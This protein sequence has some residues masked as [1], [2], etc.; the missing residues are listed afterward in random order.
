MIWGIIAG[1]AFL[2]FCVLLYL[3]VRKNQELSR[4][5]LQERF[6]SLQ[7]L[8]DQKISDTSTITHAE[9]TKL[10][11]RIDGRLRESAE[12][13]E[14]THQT[15]GQ[16]LDKNASLFGEVKHKL[17]QLEESSKRIESVGENISELQEIL[18]APK[19]RGN[20][21]ELFL[22]ELLTQILP[23][24]YFEM[25]YTFHS[26]EKVD[27][28]IRLAHGLVP[29]D[30]KFPLENFQKFLKPHLSEQEE[31]GFRKKFV[32]DLKK[33]VDD[34][35]QR[36]IR[37]DEGTFDFALLYV[38]AENIYYE[39][40]LREDGKKNLLNINAYALERRVIPV[41][42]NSLYAYLQAIVLGLKGLQIEER[43]KEIFGS[44]AR[45]KG[46]MGKLEEE[47]GLVGK[48]LTNASSAF[49]KTKKRTQRL[50]DR[51]TQIEEG[52]DSSDSK[53]VASNIPPQIPGQ[54]R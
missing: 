26:G 22:E 12:A 24:D 44:L 25:Q 37:P 23:K 49:D 29:I 32:N 7:E 48:H 36:Y 47:L 41:S 9:L 45:L 21:G 18:R 1:T 54:I 52:K 34:I 40:I 51:L 31:L 43:A 53:Q 10:H 20:L 6:Q 42:P 38:P 46:E 50:A 27:A 5:L 33:H 8:L 3:L 39:A 11:T 30:A 15:V 13:I 14:K 19:L 2:L 4:H 35:A 28:V 17:G 16:R